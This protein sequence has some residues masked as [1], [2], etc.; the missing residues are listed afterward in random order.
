MKKVVLA[1]GNEGKLNEMQ[2]IL[3]PLQWELVTQSSLSIEPAEETGLSFV[4]NAILKAR[5]ASEQSGL[6]AIAD[7]SGLVV[8]ALAGAP[9]IYS[10]R[11]AGN[12]AD[13]QTNI[14]KLLSN[15]SQTPES[16]CQAYFYCTI[17]YVEHHL[18]PTPLIAQGRFDGMI[19]N[20][21]QGQGGF[22]YDP[23][24]WLPQFNLTA[25]QIPAEL[26]NKISHRAKALQQLIKQLTS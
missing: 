14:D 5:H 15:L 17:A 7:D 8:N 9:G 18:S 23:I 25:A 21:Q 4:E 11:Y 19:I 13:S 24:F 16:E 12:D 26:K 6:G 1:S 22:G 20:Q 10:A 2:A 3:A